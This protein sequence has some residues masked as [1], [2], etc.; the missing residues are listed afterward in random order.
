[1]NPDIL[2]EASEARG[3]RRQPVIVGFAA[4]TTN[5]TENARKKLEGK[6]LDLV[7]ANDVSLEG[8]GFASDFNK[9]VLLRRDGG[10]DELP[11]LPK[12]DVAH[13]LW[14]EVRKIRGAGA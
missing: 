7:V 11:L 12:I 5:L 10:L 2:E 14:D 8:S 4:E 6:R 1:V 3:E 13:R 9:V